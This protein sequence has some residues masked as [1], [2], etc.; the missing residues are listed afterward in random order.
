[1]FFNFKVCL[2]MCFCSLK[3]IKVGYYEFSQN[4]KIVTEGAS[5]ISATEPKNI[6]IHAGFEILGLG[7]PILYGSLQG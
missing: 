2:T 4:P 7:G 5:M 3:E 1:M 6:V